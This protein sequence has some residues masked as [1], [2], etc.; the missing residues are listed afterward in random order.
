MKK[1]LGRPAQSIIGQVSADIREKQKELS[2]LRQDEKRYREQK[3]QK[4]KEALDLQRRIQAEEEKRR[5]LQDDPDADKKVLE[6][7]EGL[8]KNLKKDLKTKQKENTRLQKHY[9][10]SQKK[11]QKI[12]QLETS[13]LQEEQKRDSMERRLNST[14]TF[15]A[16]KEQENNLLRQ[17][18][19]DQAIINDEGA[20][21]FDKEAAEE[22]I[23][24]RNEELARLQTQIAEREDA[25]PLREKIKEIFKK[26]GV[27][28][29]FL[30]RASLLE[31]FLELLPK[32]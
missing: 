2:Q 14:R 12:G 1:A 32:L 13:I 18:E 28:V 16:L 7:K 22:H 8:I 17:N 30:L 23:A 21:E 25:M 24:A 3:E 19:E 9:E 11:T 31:Q 27:T 20:A 5:Q 10:D 26:H 4:E 15:D 6:Q 29:T